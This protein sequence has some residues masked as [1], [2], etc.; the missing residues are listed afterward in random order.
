MRTLKLNEQFKAEV[1]TAKDNIGAMFQAQL[2]GLR[3][4]FGDQTWT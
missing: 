2:E 4:V 1:G 3:W